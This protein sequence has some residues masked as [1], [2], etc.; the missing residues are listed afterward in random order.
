M[1][2]FLSVTLMSVIA[3]GVISLPAFGE[4][5]GEGGGKGRRKRVRDRRGER[6]K[7][8]FEKLVKDLGLT[9]DQQEQVRQ[10]LKASRD[11]RKNYQQEHGEQLK[12][13][14]EEMR[15][16]RESG[17]KDAIKAA[18]AK[19][20]K[21]REA[22]QQMGANLDTQLAD[23]L[24]EEQMK[25]FKALRAR[26]GPQ[27]RPGASL[28][29]ALR[30]L[31]LTE[32]QRGKVKK[33][34]AEAKAKA[35]EAESAEDKQKIMSAATENIRKDVL[36][37]AQRKKLAELRDKPAR[38]GARG[39]MFKGLDLTEEQQKKIDAIR[40]AGR[41]KVQEADGREA[42][43]AAQRAMREQVNAVLTEQQREKLK[44]R[45]RAGQ[46]GRE[47]RRRG[48]RRDGPGGKTD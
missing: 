4:G 29:G 21:H 33:I 41:K 9:A 1:K 8:M 45:V 31:D 3:L 36:T 27:R 22:L 18:A 2:K 37:E 19:M 11:E 43:R 48:R 46:R 32:E 26:R 12:A 23:V 47:G 34:M 44:K 17:D 5:E 10:K 40:A 38:G 30:R 16:A 39:G 14:R 25:K 15:K 7:A 13:L 20:K 28:L 6:G 42:K 35:K 24:T